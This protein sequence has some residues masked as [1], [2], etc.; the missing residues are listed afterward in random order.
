MFVG[1]RFYK[2]AAPTALT[3]ADES[4]CRRKFSGRAK[5]AVRSAGRRSP[6]GVPDVGREIISRGNPAASIFEA[7]L[8]VLWLWRRV[9]VEIDRLELAHYFPP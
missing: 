6:R 8:F 5:A 1:G 2:D 4:H 7:V 3:R 9:T